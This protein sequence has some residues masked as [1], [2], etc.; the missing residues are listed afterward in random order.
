MDLDLLR[1]ITSQRQVEKISVVSQIPEGV[2]EIRLELVP[3][4]A[5]FLS[6]LHCHCHF[7]DTSESPGMSLK[8][9]AGR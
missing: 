1:V 5:E 8:M 7:Q 2:P 4:K 6:M 9:A 3:A